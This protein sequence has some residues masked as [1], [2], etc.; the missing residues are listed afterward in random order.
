MGFSSHLY[1]EPSLIRRTYVEAIGTDVP[2]VP[3]EVG[4]RERKDILEVVILS[5][6]FSARFSRCSWPRILPR[7]IRKRL[8]DNRSR[9]ISR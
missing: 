1:V 4:K 9:L 8:V 2:R 7:P 5:H 3:G 6:P